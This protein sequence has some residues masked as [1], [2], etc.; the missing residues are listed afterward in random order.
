MHFKTSCRVEQ[1]I[2]LFK[3]TRFF[4][5]QNVVKIQSISIKVRGGFKNNAY[6]HYHLHR[7]CTFHT[8]ENNPV[9]TSS[10][11]NAVD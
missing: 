6:L 8:K 9:S 1:I 11:N 10:V 2:I 4:K 3:I 7:W 5:L